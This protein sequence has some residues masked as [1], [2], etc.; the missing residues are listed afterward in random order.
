MAVVN[1]VHCG[2]ASV[3]NV[4]YVYGFM[5]KLI[6]ANH[7][8]HNSSI[9]IHIWCLVFC[10]HL[11]GNVFTCT[12]CNCNHIIH[13]IAS[14]QDCYVLLT[15]PIFQFIYMYA[16]YKIQLLYRMQDVLFESVLLKMVYM[17]NDSRYSK[18][19]NYTLHC[20]LYSYV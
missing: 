10:V 12:T 7:D 6:F 3:S 4:M 2:K 18:F 11:N 14:K 17:Q 13:P 20:V 8:L 16:M 19:L 9:H 5:L 1:I 15:Y